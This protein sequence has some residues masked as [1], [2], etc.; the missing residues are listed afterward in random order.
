[1]I[2]FFITPWEAAQKVLKNTK[3]KYTIKHTKTEDYEIESKR[4][5]QKYIQ[6]NRNQ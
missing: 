4:I 6:R 1:M 2:S 5:L 3:Y